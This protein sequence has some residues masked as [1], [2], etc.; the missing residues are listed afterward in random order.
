MKK[1]LILNIFVISFILI[2]QPVFARDP[3]RPLISEQVPVVESSSPQI[4]EEQQN[5]EMPPD[6]PQRQ[7]SGL[8]VSGILNVKKEVYALVDYEGSSFTVRQGEGF[9][10]R[11]LLKEINLRLRYVV[12]LDKTNNEI[13]KIKMEETNE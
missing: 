13:K 12:I 2:A 8:H 7:G 5:I 11:F 3:F 1:L 9:A 10:G 4:P 6:E